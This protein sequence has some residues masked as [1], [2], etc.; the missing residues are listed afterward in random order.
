M[1][2]LQIFDNPEFGKIRTVERDGEPWFV[3]KDVAAALGYE[4]PQNAIAAHVDNEDKTTALIQGTGSNYK[5]NAVLI[6]ESGL[7]SLVL[8]SKLPTARKFKRWVTSEVIPTIRKH[9]AYMT[10]DKLEEVLLNPDTLIQLAQNL[11][12]EQEARR[13]AEAKIEAD[14]PKVLFADA[15]STSEQSILVGQLAKIIRQNGVPMGERRLFQWMRENGYLG[16][17]GSRYNIPTQRSM[18][19]G[20]FEIKETAVTHSDGRVTTNTT[21]KVTGKGQIYFVNC[22]LA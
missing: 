8:S 5:S 17:H 7:Y 2:E 3:G 18:E 6:N 22:F 15:V 12:S 13:A 9:K 14:H 21:P 1:N 16:K 19:M 20:L 4:K 11:K 10:P